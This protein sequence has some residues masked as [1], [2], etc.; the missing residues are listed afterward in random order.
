MLGTPLGLRKWV[1]L[2]TLGVKKIQSSS[3]IVLT[4]TCKLLKRKLNLKSIKKSPLFF[5]YLFKTL[6]KVKFWYL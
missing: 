5:L 4:L 3:V 1:E 6:G 2:S